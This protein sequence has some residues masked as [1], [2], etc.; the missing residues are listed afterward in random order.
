MRASKLL[1]DGAELAVPVTFEVVDLLLHR[2]Q[3]LLHGSQRTK[4]RLLA[5]VAFIAQRLI[6]C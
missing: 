3:G 2:L 6:G 4:H 5:P 1:C